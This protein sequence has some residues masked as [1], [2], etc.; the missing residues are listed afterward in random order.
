MIF[1]RAASARPVPVSFANRGAFHGFT[2]SKSRVP[3]SQAHIP[4]TKSSI[5]VLSP[6]IYQAVVKQRQPLS[7][8]DFPYTYKRSGLRGR[9]RGVWV[10]CDFH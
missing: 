2:D 5:G 10:P 8:L 7:S 3:G 1:Q 6:R 9:F 4:S